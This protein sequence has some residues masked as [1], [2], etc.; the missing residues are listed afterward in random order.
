M[1]STQ[2]HG[3][4]SQDNDNDEV[5]KTNTVIAKLSNPLTVGYFFINAVN[6]ELVTPKV[7]LL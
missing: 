3:D 1:L 5:R 6:R 4:K 2:H 7:I